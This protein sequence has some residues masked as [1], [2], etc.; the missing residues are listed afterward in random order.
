M[1]PEHY[2]CCSVSLAWHKPV[3]YPGMRDA[4]HRQRCCQT[5]GCARSAGLH[6]ATTKNEKNRAAPVRRRSAAAPGWSENRYTAWSCQVPRSCGRHSSEHECARRRWHFIVWSGCPPPSCMM[7]RLALARLFQL[8][9]SP[10]RVPVRRSQAIFPSFS[11]K[12]FC[13]NL[14]CLGP[15]FRGRKY[16]PTRSFASGTQDRA[17]SELDR[18]STPCLVSQPGAGEG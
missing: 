12:V 16:G 3:A 14:R 8:P 13:M 6:V 1:S 9:R 2:S 18:G 11:S 7:V 5:L 4:A 17:R 15:R 10:H